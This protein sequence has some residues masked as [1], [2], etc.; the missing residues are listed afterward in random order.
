MS[1]P[2]PISRHKESKHI[3][4]DWEDEDEDEEPQVTQDSKTIWDEANKRP[5]TNNMPIIMA[6]TGG[7]SSVPFVPPAEAFNKP[8]QILRRQPASSSGTQTPNSGQSTP[9][10][11][12]GKH[13]TLADREKAYLDA[14]GRIFGKSDSPDSA[15]PHNSGP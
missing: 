8:R 10:D 15:A 9:R 2:T 3:P 11:G 4:D 13:H 6:K 7:G 12:E 14:R 5:A 1:S